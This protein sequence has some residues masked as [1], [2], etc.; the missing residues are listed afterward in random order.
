MK[1]FLF[2]VS[3]LCILTFD[4]TAQKVFTE[5]V[6][7]YNISIESTNGEKPVSSALNGAV[8]TLYLTKDKSRSE[9]LSTPGKETIVFD[10]KADKGFILK[11]Y[12]GQKLM[13]TATGD[14]WAQ[15]NQ[16]KRS[17]NFRTE[18]GTF[19]VGDFSCKK[20]EAEGLDGKKYIVY[21]DPSLEITNHSYNNAFPQIQGLP[22]RFELRSG[23][24]VFKYTL[25]KYSQESIAANKFDVPKTG[26][27][28]MTYEENQQ[29]KKGE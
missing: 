21:Y 1:S 26:F 18:Q 24:L 19:T 23:N 29:L 20:A 8:L 12:S 14:N 28:V 11:E 6:L 9:M 15:K 16:T 4:S 5:G 2:L 17:L 10:E 7:T 27:R 3:F 13:I 25:V 22:V